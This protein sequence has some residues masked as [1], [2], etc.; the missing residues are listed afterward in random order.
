[1]GQA[2]IFPESVVNESVPDPVLPGTGKSIFLCLFTGDHI[3]FIHIFSR[4]LRMHMKFQKRIIG[5]VLVFLLLFTGFAFM[6]SQ[7][8]TNGEQDVS[9]VIEVR[10]AE[11]L[12]EIS[13][14]PNGLLTEVAVMEN[15]PMI[16]TAKLSQ[17][18]KL[19]GITSNSENDVPVLGTET[20]PQTQADAVIQTVSELTQ[21]WEASI[22]GKAGWFHLQTQIYVP[23]TWRGNGLPEIAMSDLFP[24]DISIQ[25][26]WFH[27]DEAGHY[28]ESLSLVS[29]VDGTIQ[30]QVIF[31]DGRLVNLTLLEAGV[32]TP[33]SEVNQMQKSL[34]LPESDALAT[35]NT[36]RGWNRTFQ[37]WLSEDGGAYTVITEQVF[38][39]TVE[40]ANA[41]EPIQGDR[42]TYTF[43][44]HTGQLIS[45]EFQ[46]LTKSGLWLTLEK[47]DYLV[48]ELQTD[49]PA[50]TRQIFEESITQLKEGN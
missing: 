48:A 33:N 26:E 1:M 34:L 25:D 14:E 47:K 8:Q 9:K 4:R 35:L 20:T 32:T 3:A 28:A 39:T 6:V 17:D 7:T 21:K 12:S 43:D 29:T 46:V 5:T 50:D 15:L 24:E 44:W 19:P 30:Q 22:L 10:E 2:K 45:T 42:V 38:T 31:S 36:Y 49:L 37:A 23:A 16:T 11:N 18:E 40:I 13:Q 27:I 41:P